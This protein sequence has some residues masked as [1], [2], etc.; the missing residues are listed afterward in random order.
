MTVVTTTLRTMKEVV[1]PREFAT[2]VVVGVEPFKLQSQHTVSVISHRQKCKDIC[3]VSL[4]SESRI[5]EIRNT[6]FLDWKEMPLAL[7]T[8]SGCGSYVRSVK[9]SF[10][11]T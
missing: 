9:F 4:G 7:F 8:C 1:D 6:R 2:T 10:D 11:S 3:R 5:Y